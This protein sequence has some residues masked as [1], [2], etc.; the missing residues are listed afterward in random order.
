MYI[1]IFIL[2]IYGYSYEVLYLALEYNRLLLILLWY[3]IRC[4]ALYENSQN[5]SCKWRV[6]P[7]EEFT[8]PQRP[9]RQA[10]VT[11]V[12]L[13]F[14]RYKHAFILIAYRVGSVL[15]YSTAS[16]VSSNVIIPTHALALAA[17]HFVCKKKSLR[18]RTCVCALGGNWTHETDF[19]RHHQ[20][21][22][23][24]GKIRMNND[25]NHNARP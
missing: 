13:F 21:Q 12:V 8:Y 15:S 10:E 19:S 7:Q 18:V 20:L 4:I 11:G 17:N 3:D 5:P 25:V 9:C 22:I 23:A 16:R 1:R 2:Y 6:Y 24:T 14:P